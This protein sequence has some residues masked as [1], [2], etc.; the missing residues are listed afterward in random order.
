MSSITEFVHQKFKDYRYYRT[1][2][3]V[4]LPMHLNMITLPHYSCNITGSLSHIKFSLRS[5]HSLIRWF[6]LNS[7]DS[8]YYHPLCSLACFIFSSRKST[9]YPLV[10]L[11][12]LKYAQLVAFFFITPVLWNALPY[13]ILKLHQ[14]RSMPPLKCTSFIL[15]SGGPA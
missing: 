7:L 12:R 4:C 9:L 14:K 5:P 1:L 10:S 6:I 2:L 15:P 13:Y 3:S 11:A 8:I